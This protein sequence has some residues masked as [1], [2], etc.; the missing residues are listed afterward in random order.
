MV[1]QPKQSH[2]LSP[3]FLTVFFYCFCNF[4]LAFADDLLE[5]A[6]LSGANWLNAQQSNSPLTKGAFGDEKTAQVDTYET[7]K[8]LQYLNLNRETRQKIV[9]WYQLQNNSDTDLLARK[10]EILSATYLPLQELTDQLIA[11]Q[12]KDGGWGLSPKY[13]SA[14]LH[15]LNVLNA[16]TYSN[17]P[18]E[19]L[20][21]AKVIDDAVNYLI[22]AQNEDGA[23][24]LNP[25]QD[26]NIVLT[27]SIVLSISELIRSTHYSH[28]ALNPAIE[29]AGLW[30]QNKKNPDGSWGAN[31][32]VPNTALCFSA[33]K[34]TIALEI[35]ALTDLEPTLEWLLSRQDA[36]DKSWNHS[37]YETALVLRAL[38]DDLLFSH[39]EKAD[40]SIQNIRVTPLTPTMADTIDITVVLVNQGGKT[41]KDVLV[42][43]KESSGSPSISNQEITVPSLQPGQT[44]EWNLSFNLNQG[45]YE[46][47]VEI[48]PSNAISESDETN[49]SA[50]LPLTVQPAGSGQLADLEILSS[51][52]W[53]E[54]Q[55]P[56]AQTQISLSAVVHNRG[57]QAT[58]Q[59][60]IRVRDLATDLLIGS[61]LNSIGALAPGASKPFN[62]TFS[63]S[64]GLHHLV[65]TLDPEGTIAE[66]DETNNTASRI[67]SVTP[68][69]ALPDLEL[70]AADIALT[71]DHPQSGQ[72]INLQ[73]TIH[74]LGNAAAQNVSVQFYDGDP[75][76]N[77]TPIGAAQFA[78]HIPAGGTQS[79]SI[80]DVTFSAGV[81][82][83]FVLCDGSNTI[84]ES[85]ESNNLAFAYL[86][87]GIGDL[88]D[89]TVP[90]ISINPPGPAAWQKVKISAEI[91]NLGKE[92]AD[93]VTVDFYK[94]N[95][96]QGGF[97][98]ASKNGYTIPAES[99]IFV[100]AEW[101]AIEGTHALYVL[102]DPD[103]TVAEQNESNNT[104]NQ[105]VT[106]GAGIGP[107]LDFRYFVTADFSKLP[108]NNFVNIVRMIAT[109]NN[110]SVIL[111]KRDPVFLDW[112]PLDQIILQQGE[113]WEPLVPLIPAH[114]TS[115]HV[116]L[117]EGTRIRASQPL[118]VVQYDNDEAD[119]EM[120]LLPAT[121]AWGKDYWYAGIKSFGYGAPNYLL[122]TAGTEGTHILIDLNHDGI[123][124]QQFLNLKEGDT[125]RYEDFAVESGHFIGTHYPPAA[126]G[127][128]YVGK[129]KRAGAHITSNFPI[130][131]HAFASMGDAFGSAYLLLPTEI[132]GKEYKVPFIP[133][134]TARFPGPEWD[135]AD[136][137]LIVATQDNTVINIDDPDM[138]GIE[139]ENRVLNAGQ[140]LEYPEFEDLREFYPYY[141]FQIKSHTLKSPD[142]GR[143]SYDRWQLPVT[144]SE[145]GTV[146]FDFRTDTELNSDFLRFYIDSVEM[147]EQGLPASGEDPGWKHA[148]FNLTAGNHTLSWAFDFQGEQ[149]SA[150]GINAVWMDN[151]TVKTGSNQTV[152][153]MNFDQP[154]V[155]TDIPFSPGTRVWSD[156]D[157]GVV[158][159]SPAGIYE[160]DGGAVQVIPDKSAV[161]EYWL[162]VG[163]DAYVPGYPPGAAETSRAYV[164][165]HT[166]QTTIR[167][168]FE[169]GNQFDR[170]DTDGD[171]VLDRDF[172]V[173]QKGENLI[174]ETARAGAHI[175]GDK[176][177]DMN[178]VWSFQAG[179]SF[180]NTNWGLTLQSWPDFFVE[181]ADISF[182]DDA[183]AAGVSVGIYADVH[184]R[185]N[186]TEDNVTVQFYLGS[187]NSVEGNKKCYEGSAP[188]PQPLFKITD[189]SLIQRNPDISGGRIV[190]EDESANRIIIR[191]YDAWT[192]E[193]TELKDLS[194]GAQ[195]TPDLSGSG[196]HLVYRHEQTLPD[197]PVMHAIKVYDLTVS[198]PVLRQVAEYLPDIKFNQVDSH[199][200]VWQQYLSAE[201]KYAIFMCD[202]NRSE[203]TAGS[204]YVTD[205]KIR[206]TSE[207]SR[208]FPVLSGAQ[209]GY[210]GWGY[211]SGVYRCDLDLYGYE[212]GCNPNQGEQ[213]IFG[214]A[215]NPKYPPQ[216]SG[217]RV[218]WGDAGNFRTGIP[219]QIYYCDLD[220]HPGGCISLSDNIRVT[221]GQQWN[222]NPDIDGNVMVWNSGYGPSEPRFINVCRIDLNGQKGGCLDTDE[223]YTLGA[224][225]DR[226]PKVAENLV[227][228]QHFRGEGGVQDYDIYGF[229]LD[230]FN[231]LPSLQAASGQLLGS[232][233]IP[234]LEANSTARAS[235]AYAFPS[236]SHYD[237]Y[238]CVDPSDAVKEVH[239]DNNIAGTTLTV[240]GQSSFVLTLNSDKA[241]YV[242]GETVQLSV[243]AV[244][245]GTVAAGG[246]VG[247]EIY[248]SNVNQLS[249]VLIPAHHFVDLKPQQSS[250]FIRTWAT[251][252]SIP[253][254]SYSVKA[255]LSRDG[256]TQAFAEAHFDI[257]SDVDDQTLSGKI[258]TDKQAYSADDSLTITVSAKNNSTH[259]IYKL[260]E[261][262]VRIK[263]SSGI[264]VQIFPTHSIENLL[265]QKLDELKL[266]WN[267]GIQSPALNYRAEL[268]VYE[269]LSGGVRNLVSTDFTL[270]EIKPSSADGK[271]LKGS[272]TVQPASLYKGHDV[273]FDFSVANTGNEDLNSLILQIHVID[274]VSQTSVQ[275]LNTPAFNLM[276][277]AEYHSTLSYDNVQLEPKTYMVVLQGVVNSK[278]IPVAT[279]SLEVLSD[280]TP[281]AVNLTLQ[282]ISYQNGADTFVPASS[283][284]TIE[285]TDSQS[286]VTS[287]YVQINDGP[288]QREQTQ[289]P[290]YSWSSGQASALLLPGANTLHYYS[291]DRAGNR[292][293]TQNDLLTY[294]NASPAVTVKA[295]GVTQTSSNISIARNTGVVLEAADALSGVKT[296]QVSVDGAEYQNVSTPWTSEAWSNGEHTMRYQAE[297]NVGNTL[298]EQTLTVTVK[299]VRVIM[300]L[301]H[302]GS[303]MGA[304][305]ANMKNAVI[306]LMNAFQPGDEIGIVWFNNLLERFPSAPVILPDTQNILSNQVNQ[307][308]AAGSTKLY[309]AI[310]YKTSDQGGGSSVEGS[311]EW[312][313]DLPNPEQ[314]VEVL[315]VLGDGQDSSTGGASGGSIITLQTA[316]S[317]IHQHAASRPF[318]IFTIGYGAGA[319][320]NTLMSLA[321]NHGR[322]FS[323]DTV[324]VNCIMCLIGNLVGTSTDC[325]AGNICSVSLPRA[326]QNP[327]KSLFTDGQPKTQ[328]SVVFPSKT[329][330]RLK[331]RRGIF[332]NE[333]KLPELLVKNYRFDSNPW[334]PYTGTVAIPENARTFEYEIL[335]PYEEWVRGKVDLARKKV[336]KESL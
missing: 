220:Q 179:A 264:D 205:P 304:K 200:I 217:N 21:P 328:V 1:R 68:S 31:N 55:N 318:S 99:S 301:D 132:L 6:L 269:V 265:P 209:L 34:R 173:I 249:G 149:G 96:K 245:Q 70:E 254:G 135:D 58:A 57:G 110:T 241:S 109:K 35:T 164:L 267:T 196:D 191:M 86:W 162:T 212:N 181:P 30:I 20:V 59:V 50:R 33:L 159:S 3:L 93:A 37:I 62:L 194:S 225:I 256:V 10:L 330:V 308:T 114:P 46:F 153:E 64:Q 234:L 95:P 32:A 71:H 67:I 180:S 314:F 52:I 137:I 150:N 90:Q 321:E 296:L 247:F 166:D 92:A 322:Y 119:W 117:P 239:E 87:S 335:D 124:E 243:S 232:Q 154:D 278:N 111:E 108:G 214:S 105:E 237:V 287:L 310:A 280:V 145:S 174:I 236:Q 290:S 75:F 144:L 42:Q 82:K 9:S 273:Q 271:G 26:G 18:A 229:D 226:F 285:A 291:E 177:F 188:L 292:S 98:F 24:S 266:T 127:Y 133:T 15:T 257:E 223:H 207:A 168:D 187:P 101:Y 102:A 49:N 178:Q 334:Q 259:F 211:G 84:A 2:S 312:F 19:G 81:H 88:P 16:F 100:E 118:T 235:I 4:H 163:K 222:M 140:T 94:G 80:S 311:L 253:P 238:V 192:R 297:D 224:G 182:S 201:K 45:T 316:I 160:W 170:F 14:P 43:L 185:G 130:Q 47:V 230:K 76:E 219:S 228:W 155:I 104:L 295:N 215:L 282:G 22:G 204:C 156:Q 305:L 331:V 17:L 134:H 289:T 129:D 270:F 44:F 251:A 65:F 12:N 317:R 139:L 202:L 171:G 195:R 51:E 148:S 7:F 41:A 262:D 78:P 116:G 147:T 252:V 113:K 293:E 138:P 302:S 77:G 319:D 73:A 131:A 288:W 320:V 120:T 272:L 250:D 189:N 260:L 242:P 141:P 172:A 69:A 169:G 276:K 158:Y 198:P 307:K 299:R 97:L 157:I 63:L 38:K 323:A 79:F 142:F 183:P 227:V 123:P 240:Q 193:F 244:N 27:A 284:F 233:L 281:P 112:L 74:N 303:M 161:S 115:P 279:G 85:S 125:I 91:K 208:A 143:E 206:L 326:A 197:G 210:S 213:V 246:T 28:A 61:S 263:N 261:A 248:D 151:V 165:A 25:N 324:N 255:R 315:L 54:P 329:Q 83:I 8:T 60:P 327:A 298:P 122:L 107:S 106:V 11:V 258:T 306:Q 126:D 218:V 283:S 72:S 313:R 277:S 40:L 333:W 300:A 186:K 216:F 39:Q 56:D 176:P 175:V 332:F 274:P 121:V 13:Q 5:S 146:S 231:F 268:E 103:A 190:W 286:G 221:S 184:N 36:A 29:K 294:D 89:L 48:D 136:R 199:F 167:V 23:W 203:G 336:K 128:Y 325:Y 309:D 53:I 152:V 275:T 66:S